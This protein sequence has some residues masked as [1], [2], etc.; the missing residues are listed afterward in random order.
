MNTKNP[1]MIF[2]DTVHIK[3]QSL[4]FNYPN[5]KIYEKNMKKI[6]KKGINI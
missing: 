1:Q 2:S 3:S 5:K 6:Y 4:L